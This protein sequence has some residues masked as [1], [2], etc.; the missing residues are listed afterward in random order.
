MLRRFRSI[1]IVLS[2]LALAACGEKVVKRV[3]EPASSLQQLTVNADGSWKVALRLQNFSSMPM[4]FDDIALKLSVGDA[5]AG[6]LSAKPGVSI[7]GT[8]ADVIELQLQP[9]A[10]AR[11]IVADALASNHTLAYTLEGSVSATPE[12]KK[13]RTFQINNR[14]TLNHAPGLPGVLR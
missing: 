11:L 5:E 9:A 13:Q 4:R 8:S 7:G 10:Q 1:L 6:T 2:V 14:S 12:E 3:S